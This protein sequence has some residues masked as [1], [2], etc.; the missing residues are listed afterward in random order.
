MNKLTYRRSVVDVWWNS[1]M[2]R[3]RIQTQTVLCGRDYWSL[4]SEATLVLY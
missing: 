2:L 3:N 4:A 1:S